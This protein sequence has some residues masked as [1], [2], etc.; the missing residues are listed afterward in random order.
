MFCQR[1][2]FFLRTVRFDNFRERGF[3]L[4]ENRLAAISELWDQLDNRQQ[5]YYILDNVFTVDE[6][7]VG[8][9]GQVPGRIQMPSKPQEYG[10]KFFGQ[11]PLGILECI[12][13]HWER[14]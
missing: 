4:Q 6:Q 14:W 12:N 1:F 13:L 3:R 5:K 7:L 11:I 10:I 2:K 8:C 9:G